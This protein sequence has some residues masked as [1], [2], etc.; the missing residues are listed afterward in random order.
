MGIQLEFKDG[1]RLLI[2]TQNSEKAKFTINNYIHK[3]NNNNSIG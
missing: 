1:T 2:G 3:M